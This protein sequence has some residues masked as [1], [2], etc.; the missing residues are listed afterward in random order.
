MRLA[1]G[2]IYGYISAAIMGLAFLFSLMIQ[3][4]S[5]SLIQ[6]IEAVWLLLLVPAYLFY[7]VLNKSTSRKGAMKIVIPIYI[8][9]SAV[10]SFFV[11]IMAGKYTEMLSFLTPIPVTLLVMSPS[12]Y[13]TFRTKNHVTGRELTPDRELT[14]R[15]GR[16]L[17]GIDSDPPEVAVSERLNSLMVSHT[18]GPVPLILISSH[19][20]SYD[21]NEVNAALF[22]AYFDLRKN[23]SLRLIYQINLSV[24]I[25]LDLLIIFP[26]LIN[27]ISFSALQVALL[28]GLAVV[29]LGFAPAFPM[30]IRELSIRGE[31]STDLMVAKIMGDPS[32][33]RSLILRSA[34]NKSHYIPQAPGTERRRNRV[35]RNHLTMINRRVANLDRVSR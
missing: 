19:L 15:L 6:G 27:S 29:V 10:Y 14:L 3:G 23:K 12:F 32:P 28:A 17:E 21:E 4:G 26:L 13:L 31:M 22:K 18:D 25:F 35:R 7:R 24:A 11:P 33:I 8:L 16:L 30:I 9:G 5:I 20:L 1:G 2:R 34:A